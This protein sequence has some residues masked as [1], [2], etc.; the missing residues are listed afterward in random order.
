MMIEEIKNTISEAKEE[1][2]RNYKVEVKGIFGSYAR[3]DYNAES[4]LDL[5]VDFDAGASLLDL[6]GVQ[7]YFE[8]KFGFKVDVV[9][10]H[11][12]CA[13]IHDTVLKK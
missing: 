5:L 12:L 6:V 13:E 1:L 7:L 4:D 3:G 10:R 8:D 11:A 2:R 9:S